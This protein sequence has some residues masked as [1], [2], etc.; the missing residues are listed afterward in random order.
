MKESFNILNGILDII[1]PRKLSCLFCGNPI[2]EINDFLLCRYCMSILTFI[3]ENVCIKCGR[4]FSGEYANGLCSECKNEKVY[5]DRCSSVFEF[6]GMVQSALHRLKYEGER[7]IARGIGAFMSRKLKALKWHVDI[8]LPVP[9]HEKRMKERGYNQSLLLASEVA[10]E[11]NIDLYEGVLIRNRDTESQT[12]LS[13]MERVHNVKGAFDVI[14]KKAIQGKAVL[15]IDDIMTTG[16]TLNECSK[17][18]KQEGAR[19]IYCLAAACP[20]HV[21]HASNNC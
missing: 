4:P 7:E 6:S 21:Q 5:F 15:I 11:C 9:M 18:L 20:I 13:R 8:I 14:G 16:S 2:T 12:H 1:Y 19:E 17:V 10:R 3:Q